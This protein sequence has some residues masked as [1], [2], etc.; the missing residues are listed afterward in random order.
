MIFY[1]HYMDLPRDPQFVFGHGLSYT[2]FKYSDLKV[3]PN[4]QPNTTKVVVTVTNSGKVAGSEIVQLYIQDKFATVTRPIKELKGFEKIELAPGASQ[5]V[6]FT[7][8]GD[9][10]GFFN[11]K[12]EFVIEKGMFDVMVGGSSNT[13][14]SD[15]F[16]LK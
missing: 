4:V 8:T 13:E 9:E 2:T 7:L 12:G 10:L 6:E 15:S 14:L 5:T 1:H 3:M 16:E 11:N